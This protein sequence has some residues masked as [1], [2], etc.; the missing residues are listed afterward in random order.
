MERI[1]RVFSEVGVDLINLMSSLPRRE[2]KH[3]SHCSDRRIFKYSQ[4]HCHCVIL[5]CVQ[6]FKIGL[7][8]CCQSRPIADS[9]EHYA[10][11]QQ[12]QMSLLNVFCRRGF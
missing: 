5:N 8:Q 1:A 6:I 2:V 7:L 11:V 12:K 4:D 9:T 3:V 10:L